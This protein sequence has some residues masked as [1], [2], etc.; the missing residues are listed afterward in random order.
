MKILIVMDPGISIP[1]TGYG[2]HE[3]L[4]EMFAKS[5]HKKG[6]E[7]HLLITTGSIVKGC[8]VH[9]FG[10]VGFPPSKKNARYALI[11]GCIFLWKYRNDF[12]LIH[13]FG[14]LAYLIPILNCK[15]KKIMTYGREISSRNIKWVNKLPN[16]NLI[17]TGCSENLVSRGAVS[18]KWKAVYNAVDFNLYTLQN[19]I[20]NDAPLIFLGRLERIK[21]LHTAIRVAIQTGN[22]LI[23]AGNISPLVDEMQYYENEVKPLIDGKKIKYIG[24]VND[25]QKNEWLGKSKALLFPIEWN[26]PFGIVM[27]EAMACGTPVIG[28]KK[29]SVAEVI[30]EDITGYIVNNEEEMKTAISK[31]NLIS[32]EECRKRANLKFDVDV[33]SEEYLNLF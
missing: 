19:K 30:N 25:A 18:G 2:G 17:F 16:R 23:I 33:V 14:R 20:A 12:D 32:R 13:N 26:E 28:F 6:H 15:V 8:I 1:V 7:V 29:G 11:N 24:A 22:N 9:D 3:R 4:V 10:K 21:G 5:Y 31:I 27:V